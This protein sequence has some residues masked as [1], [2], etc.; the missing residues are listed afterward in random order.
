MSY[1]YFGKLAGSTLTEIA[2]NDTA[3][4]NKKSPFTD[5][6]PGTKLLAIGEPGLSRSMNR[7]L[8][9]LSC[10]ID[11]L[12]S[13]LDSPALR[14]DIL[15]YL[16]D[17][18]TTEPT[19]LFGFPRLVLDDP[20]AVAVSGNPE[21]NLGDQG[22]AA[23]EP[24][25]TWLFVGLSSRAL[26]SGKVMKLYRDSRSS[27]NNITEDGGDSHRS[28]F[29]SVLEP[30]YVKASAA[31]SDI[32]TGQLFLGDSPHSIPDR[33][34][35]I[36]KVI[37]DLPPYS[38][39]ALTI[40][41]DAWNEDGPSIQGGANTWEEMYARPGCYVVVE[42]AAGANAGVYLLRSYS[43][44][45][46]VLTRGGLTKVTVDDG[47]G[48]T[49][50]QM[51][52]WASPD[53]DAA[54]LTVENRPYKAYVMYK[55]GNDLW[56]SSVVDGED[57][58]TGGTT[59]SRVASDAALGVG[60]IPTSGMSQFGL[61]D[62]ETGAD[63]NNLLAIGAN[64]YP[65]DFSALPSTSSSE[66]N[67]IVNAGEAVKFDITTTG[68]VSV[69]NP[70]GFLLNP[71]IGLVD[72]T[73]DKWLVRPGN[74]NV[75]CRTLTTVREQLVSH[76]ANPTEASA[77]DLSG[78]LDGNEYDYAYQTVRGSLMDIKYGS[79]SLTVGGANPAAVALND[80]YSSTRNILGPDLWFITADDGAY[81]IGES[82]QAGEITTGQN[83][84]LTH[85]NTYDSKGLVV[86]GWDDYLILS[87]VY[88]DGSSW[89]GDEIEKR[90]SDRSIVVGST[91]AANDPTST[92]TMFTLTAA[93][94][95][96]IDLPAGDLE[97]FG[98]G[99]N[100]AYHRYSSSNVNDRGSGWGNNI[101]LSTG[102]PVTIF[103]ADVAGQVA[104][105]VRSDQAA[106]SLI[107]AFDD[108]GATEHLNII[109]S[110]GIL[111][112]RASATKMD[113]NEIGGANKASLDWGTDA[114]TFDDVN[115]VTTIPLSGD[116]TTPGVEDTRIDPVLP[117]S[118]LGA[119]N[120]N[121][122]T[123]TLLKD[124]FTSEVLYGGVTTTPSANLV[125]ITASLIHQKGLRLAPSSFLSVALTDGTHYLYF[126]DSAHPAAPTSLI[127][128]ADLSGW[129]PKTDVLLSRVVVTAGT[130]TEIIDLRKPLL[131]IDRRVE[132]I[133]GEDT[134]QGAHFTK[135]SDAVKFIGAIDSTASSVP[136]A[137]AYTIKVA[138]SI[139]EVP[140][141][142]PIVM[143]TPG[144]TITSASRSQDATINWSGDQAL[145]DLNGKD[146]LSFVDLQLDYV[147]ATSSAT[148]NRFVFTN[149]NSG[150]LDGLHVEGC[151]ATSTLIGEFHG[152]F[153]SA[154][155]WASNS[156]F[157][158]NRVIGASDYGIFAEPAGSG[159]DNT[160]IR[161][162]VFIQDGPKQLAATIACV[163]LV[164]PATTINGADIAGNY[165]EGF[166][167]GIEVKGDRARVTDNV[168]NLC[169][170]YGIRHVSGNNAVYRGN[171]IFNL[172]T[173]APTVYAERRG[174]SV[175]AGT[176]IR[177]LENSVDL[178][179]ATASDFGVHL[180][181]TVT[182]SVANNVV[183]ESIT[184]D[185]D[186]SVLSNRVGGD[187]VAGTDNLISGNKLSGG[188]I[189]AGANCS[190]SSN[191][192]TVG[193]ITASTQSTVFGNTLVDG[194]ITASGGG[195]KISGNQLSNAVNGDIS[196][197]NQSNTIIK[198]NIVAGDVTLGTSNSGNCSVSGN[199]ITGDL[200]SDGSDNVLTSNVIGGNI[201]HD[202]TGTSGSVISDNALTGGNITLTGATNHKNTITGN[203]NV[204]TLAL[205][206]SGSHKVSDNDID[207]LT[208]TGTGN[209]IHANTITNAVTM[210]SNDNVFAFNIVEAA[211]T[212]SGSNNAVTSNKFTASTGTFTFGGTGSAY[213]ANTLP[214]TTGN[215]AFSGTECTYTGNTLRADANTS[216]TVTL[217]STDNTFSGN[218]ILSTNAS[219][220]LALVL[221]G[222]GH[223]VADNTVD[224]V[225]FATGASD[226]SFTGNVV[227]LGPAGALGSVSLGIGTTRCV[228]S[229]NTIDGASPS[230]AGSTNTA[231]NNTFSSNWC[232]SSIQAGS[233]DNNVVTG[234]TLGADTGSDSVVAS[235]DNT[236]VSNNRCTGHIELTGGA[237][238]NVQSNIVTGAERYIIV[239]TADGIIIG[240]RCSG[241]S[242]TA[243]G[244]GA[245]APSGTVVMGNKVGSVTTTPPQGLVF[246]VDET[247]TSVNVNNS[248]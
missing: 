52:T 156:S 99:L 7:A 107:T 43:D 178:N 198:D 140:A 1:K 124:F 218:S 248:E 28:T 230:V 98:Y 4:P 37:T 207:T 173:S 76:G 197:V 93:V 75:A 51:V 224:E 195:C 234:N 170:E 130:V 222:S 10:N 86:T 111:E 122:D 30:A 189:T 149:S 244:A 100:D 53:N 95:P 135:L 226:I 81:G 102:R 31:S 203:T 214:D 106:F 216:G 143:P 80:W 33:I 138:G 45:K 108:A 19:S 97:P 70:P 167:F 220:S 35:P 84:T 213:S 88:R 117:Q 90:R 112:V 120:Y 176:G 235:G 50:G 15:H 55:N 73:T 219:F 12:A 74:Y 6:S 41:V 190:V 151:L 29:S 5:Q 165:I 85:T 36:A 206:A 92:P 245:A 180:A 72:T 62:G 148:N 96:T 238:V 141:D 49:A 82:F 204:G 104:I 32:N 211:F 57:F 139:T 132:I 116:G 66:I 21:I 194:S 212:G 225:D 232:A 150:N 42:G 89:P 247:A 22:S 40:T 142:L 59:G 188:D 3:P 101:Y 201:T 243:A 186:S 78:L 217:S 105:D 161:D 184:V 227:S 136:V 23:V 146:R 2:L 94:A 25:P 171:A 131:S 9:A 103:P 115:T 237:G 34:P 121:A 205:G 199:V 181:N 155:G 221:D 168:I 236:V 27:V 134:D 67:T 158:R 169:D 179:A 125:D 157:L 182:G 44:D 58:T 164:P 61:Y 177:V 196:A 239:D 18:N 65:T 16:D 209:A 17:P 193:N 64:L 71:V 137:R 109:N 162:N 118:I 175:D 24:P 185:D 114:L 208:F 77:E 133:V 8:G 13:Y 192:I 246:T 228:L 127:D 240:N 123:P 126:D 38:G 166:S 229:G 47:S 68:T 215:I 153:Y 20:D 223:T 144:I 87:G 160:V 129:D 128:A 63:T 145:F 231:G 183:S 14:G 39:A 48:F 79:D 91:V 11:T 241:I 233:G 110:A 56:L 242:T 113:L 54:G 119:L 202:H 26:T 154:S 210:S 69:C 187:I 172:H 174:I 159:W 200:I 83:I 152:F 191:N 46:A 60:H 147:D 163:E